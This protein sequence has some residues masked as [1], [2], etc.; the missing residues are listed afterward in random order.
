M[1]LRRMEDRIEELF[2]SAPDPGGGATRLAYSL[3]TG[4]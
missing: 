4:W 1:D 2:A 3:E